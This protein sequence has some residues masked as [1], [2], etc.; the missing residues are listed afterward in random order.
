M[1][2][3]LCRVSFESSSK[4][5]RHLQTKKH[6]KMERYKRMME[7]DSR[8]RSPVNTVHFCPTTTTDAASAEHPHSSH[9][10]EVAVQGESPFL[11]DKPATEVRNKRVKL[12]VEIQNFGV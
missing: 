12:L 8:P 11:E 6:E 4:L 10:L 9:T 1:E 2:C 3:A 5:N 7:S